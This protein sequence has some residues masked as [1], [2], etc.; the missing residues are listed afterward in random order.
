M[1]KKTVFTILFIMLISVAVIS[2]YSTF[3]YDEEA[4]KLEESTADYNLIYSM[5]ELSQNEATV[6]PKETKFIDVTLGNDYEAVIKYGMYYHL[7]SPNKLPDNVSIALAEESPNQVEDTIAAGESKT[8]T[9]KIVNN[10]DESIDIIV[11]ALVGFENGNVNELI[12]DG[13][14]LIK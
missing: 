2:L 14:V 7:L 10:S 13:E 6:A 1:T 9:I 3:A 12:K 8:I 5:K 11:G 4:A